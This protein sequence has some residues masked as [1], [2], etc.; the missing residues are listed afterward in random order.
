MRSATSSWAPTPTPPAPSSACVGKD[1]TNERKQG[2]ALFLC[3][4]VPPNANQVSILAHPS[5]R[6]FS[7]RCTASKRLF[8]CYGR[9][10]R[11]LR[12]QIHV[13]FRYDPSRNRTIGDRVSASVNH[14]V[15]L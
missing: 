3:L 12:Q 7:H 13:R 9:Y 4:P 10:L 11:G 6:R 1:R 15:Q 5:A 8:L 14:Y 2:H